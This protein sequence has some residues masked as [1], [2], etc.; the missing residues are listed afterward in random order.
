[1]AQKA[2]LVYAASIS[3][4]SYIYTN[5]LEGVIQLHVAYN[6]ILK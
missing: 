4:K 5:Y 2:V 6:L 3:G 1:L